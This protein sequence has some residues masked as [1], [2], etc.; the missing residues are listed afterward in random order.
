VPGTHGVSHALLK[1]VEPFR[2]S[3]LV[4]YTTAFLS[5]FIVE[6]YQIVLLDAAQASQ[7]AMTRK[8]YEMCAA[9]VPGDTHRNLQIHPVFS[10]QTFKHILVPVW[11]LSYLYGT[12]NYQVVV[13][14]YDGRMAGEYPK[15]P[16]KIALLVLL[17][18]IAV[19]IFALLNQN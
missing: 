13:N 18:I 11:L 7:D 4:P 19:L 14:G 1:E 6:H 16:W 5:G 9:E 10:G 3:E 15:S 8:L 2:T 17:A 12:R